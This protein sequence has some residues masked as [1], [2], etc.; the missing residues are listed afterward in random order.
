MECQPLRVAQ[1][2][3]DVQQVLRNW[4]FELLA[5]D[6]PELLEHPLVGRVGT[7]QAEMV[8]HLLV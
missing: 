8:V 3:Q 7:H 1:G 2:P 6:L 4:L 5:P